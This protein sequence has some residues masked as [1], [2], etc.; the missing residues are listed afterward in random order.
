M[1]EMQLMKTKQAMK[2]MPVKMQTRP[3]ETSP[4]EMCRAPAEGGQQQRFGGGQQPSWA[5][6]RT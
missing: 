4:N 5:S 1:A 2:N 6:P 3:V